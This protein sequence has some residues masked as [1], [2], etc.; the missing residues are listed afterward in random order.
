[1]VTANRN[2]PNETTPYATQSID[3]FNSAAL[4]PFPLPSAI[5]LPLTSDPTP[6]TFVTLSPKA[7][8]SGE[9]TTPY[10]W[11]AIP[12]SAGTLADPL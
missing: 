7:V 10:Y 2:K 8:S 3:T 6:Q 11:Y 4:S 12:P 1:M 5:T 9:T